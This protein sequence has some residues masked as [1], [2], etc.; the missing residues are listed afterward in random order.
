MISWW[1]SGHACVPLSQQSHSQFV[2]RLS[3]STG[4]SEGEASPRKNL[5]AELL[6]HSI[7]QRNDDTLEFLER[8]P[9][10]P[11]KPCVTPLPLKGSSGV[12][13][14]RPQHAQS[15]RQSLRQ[16]LYLGGAELER[17]LSCALGTTQDS[18]KP[19]LLT[20]PEL[21]PGVKPHCSAAIADTGLIASQ[22]PALAPTPAAAAAATA[23]PGGVQLQSPLGN[24]HS[25]PAH[26]PLLNAVLLSQAALQS[27]PAGCHSPRLLRLPSLGSHSQ[28]SEQS[29]SPKPS[30]TNWGWSDC[31]PSGSPRQVKCGSP[32][33][34]SI[35]LDERRQQMTRVSATIDELLAAI[36][37]D[38]VTEE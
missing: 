5:L 34:G 16:L 29:L 37:G 36:V 20:Q 2:L 18:S 26:S 28:S 6:Q 25:S 27:P 12:S 22:A 14:V 4:S 3:C 11:L 23:Q 19:S 33:F 1:R 35:P 31:Q 15:E 30:F 13:G 17:Q 21:E 32:R 8:C 9:V 10:L 38:M 24:R 7:M